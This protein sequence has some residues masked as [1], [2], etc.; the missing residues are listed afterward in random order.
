MILFIG[1]YSYVVWGLFGDFWI[2]SLKYGVWEVEEDE[3]GDVIVK[4]FVLGVLGMYVL[5]YCLVR[6]FDEE[7]G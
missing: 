3:G 1:C 6:I 7:V 4:L 5:S 2:V